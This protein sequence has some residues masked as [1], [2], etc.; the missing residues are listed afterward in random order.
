VKPPKKDV[1]IL[2]YSNKYYAV[3][4]KYAG[5]TRAYSEEFVG[6]V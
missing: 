3:F 5:K 1:W 6:Y 2:L 4:I